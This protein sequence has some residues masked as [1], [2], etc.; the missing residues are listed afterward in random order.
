[1]EELA[2][3]VV[4]ITEFDELVELNLPENEEGF[5]EGFKDA[6]EEKEYW[7]EVEEIFKMF[8]TSEQKRDAITNAK[9]K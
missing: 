7:K 6:E 5:T 4:L 3:K 8:P 2:E 9:S 1:M